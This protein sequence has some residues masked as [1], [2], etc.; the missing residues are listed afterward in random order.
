MIAILLMS[1]AILL[2]GIVMLYQIKFN[3]LIA[4]EL[5]L[6]RRVLAHLLDSEREHDD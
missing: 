4:E 3:K 2:F 5:D 1:A 6:H